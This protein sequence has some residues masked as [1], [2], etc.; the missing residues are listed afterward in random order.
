MSKRKLVRGTIYFISIGILFILGWYALVIA[1]DQVKE[2]EAM[3]FE[4]RSDEEKAVDVI[5]DET[6]MTVSEAE[7]R[8]VK[9]LDKRDAKD[10]VKVKYPKVVFVADDKI[11]YEGD[12]PDTKLIRFHNKNGSVKK[13]YPVQKVIPG[14]QW[15]A[16]IRLSN[17]KKFIGV[18]NVK[19]CNEKGDILDSETIVLNTEGDV[20]WETKH[21][22]SS[23]WVSP[24]GRYVVGSEVEWDEE[25]AKIFYQD[26]R[27]KDISKNGTLG[28]NHVQFSNNGTFVVIT[29]ETVDRKKNEKILEQTGKHQGG[30]SRHL[31]AIDEDG[32]ELWLINNI[33]EGGEYGVWDLNITDEDES[34]FTIFKIGTDEKTEFRFD[35]SGK[36]VNK[37][38]YKG[39]E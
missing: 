17:N 9:S 23:V 13:E 36:L 31:V 24:N 28:Y 32:K 21:K 10:K 34:V 25:P 18:T 12:E 29:F 30:H 19:K 3:V 20:L 14:K 27:V 15:G 35:T 38:S 39:K 7:A 8:G 11:Y 16:N 5:Y 37:K 22:L 33:T 26:G 4:Y 6:E 1:E 2:E